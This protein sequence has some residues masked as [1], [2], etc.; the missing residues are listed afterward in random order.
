MAYCT[1]PPNTS[2]NRYLRDCSHL[3]AFT[4]SALHFFHLPSKTCKTK[5]SI[6]CHSFRYPPRQVRTNVCNNLQIKSARLPLVQGGGSWNRVAICSRPR[7]PMDWEGGGTRM[8][9]NDTKLSYFLK[10]TFSLLV[11]ACWKWTFDYFPEIPHSWFRQ[12]LQLLVFFLFAI[13]MGDW[14]LGVS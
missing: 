5:M 3:V 4:N 8:S 9:K 2:C 11:F 7:S 12:L 13:S 14:E 10:M 1:S 6:L